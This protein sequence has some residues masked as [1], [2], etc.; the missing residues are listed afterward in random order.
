MLSRVWEFPPDP[1]KAAGGI[2]L[3][4]VELEVFP[5]NLEGVDSAKRG[6]RFKLM[7]DKAGVGFFEIKGIAVMSDGNITRAKELVQL[8]DQEPVVLEVL[9]VPL[10]IGQGPDYDVS[11][12]GPAV[13][14]A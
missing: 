14:E 10:K 4:R 3:I 1:E 9:L 5:K 12:V 8:F 2:Q 7:V 11:F 13:G 6:R